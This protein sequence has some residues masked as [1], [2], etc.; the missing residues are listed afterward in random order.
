[1]GRKYEENYRE[2][3][4]TDGDCFVINGCQLTAAAHLVLKVDVPFEFTVGKKT[5]PAGE[6]RV[7]RIAPHTLALR[8]SKDRFLTSVM[9]GSV[10]S[11]KARPA[12]K[13]KFELKDGRYRLAKSGLPVGLRVIGCPCRN[14]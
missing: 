4:F 3:N 8:D 2:Y 1:M 7:V 11:F 14:G 5:F 13:L 12:P 6:Y 10:V 9:T